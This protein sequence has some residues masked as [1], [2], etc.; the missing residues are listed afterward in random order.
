MLV[1]GMYG[2]TGLAAFATILLLP[3]V[4]ALRPPAD[5]AAAIQP[6]LRPALAALILMVVIDNLLNGAM[7][8]PYLLIMGG[9]AAVR[10]SDRGAG[11]A[12]I[13]SATSDLR[14]SEQPGL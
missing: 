4:R 8:L 12:L 7:I 10:G 6:D 5:G 3:I 1:F 2:L 14:R 11:T 9:L 13:D